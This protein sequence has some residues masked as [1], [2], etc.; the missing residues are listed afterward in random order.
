MFAAEIHCCDDVCH[1]RAPRDETRSPVN[2]SIIDF[3][4]FIVACVTWLNQLATQV[5]SQGSSRFFG[6]HLVLPL[7]MVSAQRTL[8]WRN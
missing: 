5:V 2:H 7:K 4:S 3:A 1:I 6:E 8:G